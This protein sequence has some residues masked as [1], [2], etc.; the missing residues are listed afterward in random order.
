MHV[1]N[2]KWIIDTESRHMKSICSSKVA[3]MFNVAWITF[4]FRCDEKNS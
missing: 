2:M 3:Y 4:T 1:I